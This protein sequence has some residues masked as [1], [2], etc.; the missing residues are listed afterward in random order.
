[1]RKPALRTGV[2]DAGRLEK[3]TLTHKEI[4]ERYMYAGAISRNPGAVAAMFT[5]DGCTRLR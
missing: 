3:V 2:V 1:M 4:F 5:E